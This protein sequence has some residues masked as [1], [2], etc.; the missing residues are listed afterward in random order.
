MIKKLNIRLVAAD[1]WQ[2]IKLLSDIDNDRSLKCKTFTHSLKYKGFMDYKDSLMAKLIRFPH[3]E[4]K[5]EQI[6]LA[7]NDSYPYGFEGKP[8]SHFIFQNLTVEDKM[9]KTVAKGEGTTDDIFRAAVLAHHC[10]TQEPDFKH[11]FKGF[12]LV[13]L[14]EE[15]QL[16]QF[17]IR[18]EIIMGVE[19][20]VYVLYQQVG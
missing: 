3:P 15:G 4:I 19:V 2:S 9:G 7:G 10:L 5:W 14:V 18:E 16:L 1:R 12:L 17:Q 6:E 8:I 11:L 13:L 20:L